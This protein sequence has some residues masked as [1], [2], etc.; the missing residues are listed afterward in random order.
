MAKRIEL[1]GLEMYLLPQ[2]ALYIPSYQLLVISDW[3][4]GKLS[5]FRR[6]GLFVPAPAAE[7]EFERLDILLQELQVKDVVFLGDLFH[8]QWNS[9]WEK[10]KAYINLHAQQ[11]LRFTLTKGNHDILKD[12]HFEN[13]SLRVKSEVILSEGI[14]LSHEPLPD[15]PNYMVNIVGHIHPGC[16]IGAGARQSFRLPCFHFKDRVLTMPAFGKFTGLHIMKPEPQADIYAVVNDA[17]ILVS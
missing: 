7:E 5:H 9:D 1:N 16:L 6:E 15:L 2:K 3:H 11:T 12:H 14:V 10:L 4:L 8:S 13:F 17:V